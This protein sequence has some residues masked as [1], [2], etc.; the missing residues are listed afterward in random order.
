[1]K[2]NM[3]EQNWKPCQSHCQMSG[4]AAALLSIQDVC[5]IF[6]GPR[7]CAVIAERELTICKKSYEKRLFCAEVQE[8]DL[9]FGADARIQFIIGQIK[10]MMQPVLLGVLTSCSLSLIGDDTRGIALAAKPGC[11][12]VA[13]DAGGLN[14][15]FCSGWQM[16]MQA[17]LEEVKFSSMNQRSARRVNLLGCC[18]GYPDAAGDVAEWKRLLEAAGFE[19]GVCLGEDGLTLP[20]IATLPQAT[21]NIVI[22]KELAE[23]LAKDLQARWQQP[24]VFAPAPYGFRQSIEWVETIGR[25]LKI[26]PQL[27]ALQQ[28]IDVAVD[29]VCEQYFLFQKMVPDFFLKR[30]VLAL[31]YSR[32]V[33]LGRALRTEV[34]DIPDIVYCIQDAAFDLHEQNID[35]AEMPPVALDTNS[36][37]LLFGS[38]GARYAG[39][40]WSHTVYINGYIPDS[41]IQRW[42][43]TYTG[44]RGWQILMDAILQQLNILCHHNQTQ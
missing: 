37:Q 9:L 18:S 39:E 28:E 30:A 11:P 42:H 23:N 29:A 13:L 24:Y 7:W 2:S 35:M 12:I 6:N 44:I 1:M 41:R 33:P 27:T 22:A 17:F 38:R 43:Q 40:H 31:P 32:A 36:Y 16:A 19:V 3:L 34:L 15:E 25:A 4:A 14:G 26:P 21:L 10:Q 20:A 5:V 8:T